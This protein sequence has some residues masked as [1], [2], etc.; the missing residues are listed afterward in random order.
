MKK[1]FA[2]L[3]SGLDL[4]GRRRKEIKIP[5]T[6]K[7]LGKRIETNI[8]SEIEI[9]PFEYQKSTSEKGTSNSWG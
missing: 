6:T 3:R 8:G 1:P 2:Y 5:A 9:P 4:G 7:I